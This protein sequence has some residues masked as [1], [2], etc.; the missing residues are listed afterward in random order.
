MGLKLQSSSGGSVELI[1]PT[2]TNNYTITLPAANGSLSIPFSGATVNTPSSGAITLTASST[3]YQV[4]QIDAYVNSYVTLPNATTMGK[5]FPVFVI[6]NNTPIGAKLFVKNASG[7]VVGSIDPAYTGYVS[8]TDNS[9]PA[10]SWS[11]ATIIDENA[12][13]N[14]DATSITALTNSPL[15]SSSSSSS[16]VSGILGLSSTSFIRY[17][18]VL[19]AGTSSSTTMYTQVCTIS[20]STVTAGS[21]Q[22]TILASNSSASYTAVTAVPNL[23]RLSDTAFVILTRVQMTDNSS[24]SPY[25]SSVKFSTNTVSG[26]TITFGAASGG[27]L[28]SSGSTNWNSYLVSNTGTI[29]RLSDTSFAVVYNDAVNLTYSYPFFYS[30]SLACQIVTVSGTTMTVGAKVQLGTSTYSTPTSIVGISSS[31]LFV[32][33]AQAATAGSSSGRTKLVTVSVSGTTPTWNTPITVETS[34]SPAFGDGTYINKT[35]CAVA[36]SSGL[37]LYQAGYF[38]STATLSGT[39]PTTGT[40]L[41]T[42]D[43]GD[44]GLTDYMYAATSTRAFFGSKTS[45]GNFFGYIDIIG[46]SGA[47]KFSNEAF[48]YQ[49]GGYSNPIYL[50]P[51]GATPT[52]S[53]IT[54]ATDCT[55]ATT[56]YALGSTT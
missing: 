42:N 32:A 41:I 1:V 27:S 34:N 31:L 44:G 51:L 23:I 5:G 39:V 48:L 2:T 28:P 37:V 14:I 20:G 54:A 18:T 47:L 21:I 10:G 19:T 3:Q 53:L 36:L 13:F 30:G 50:S 56:R 4:V 29:A 46:T 55:Y 6:K 15:Q 33:Y 8:L 52:T 40:A 16:A 17:W 22:S 43:V 7:T 49:P 45:L 11:V 9:T 35:N 25:Q 24:G 38:I 12:F 26:T